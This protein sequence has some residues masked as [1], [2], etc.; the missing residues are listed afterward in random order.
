MTPVGEIPAEENLSITYATIPSL[1]NCALSG[2]SVSAAGEVTQHGG[3]FVIVVTNTDTQQNYI[4]DSSS[5]TEVQTLT[6][7]DIETM[8]VLVSNADLHTTETAGYAY[9]ET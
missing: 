3:D 8:A 5:R 4:M 2:C 6:A 1:S 7:Q 9:Q